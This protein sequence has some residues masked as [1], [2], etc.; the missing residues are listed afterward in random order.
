M[1]GCCNQHCKAMLLLFLAAAVGA[2]PMTKRAPRPV[3]GAFVVRLCE[4]HHRA[5]VTSRVVSRHA[6][7]EAPEF[8]ATIHAHLA[9]LP[10]L[11]LVVLRNASAA[12]IA[13]LEASHEVCGI[14]ASR[15]TKLHDEDAW[16]MDRL[17]Q[18]MLPLDGDGAWSGA[19][20]AG[21]HIFVLDTGL[22]ATHE[23]FADRDWNARDLNVASYIAGDE[24]AYNPDWGWDVGDDDRRRRRDRRRRLRPR[25]GRR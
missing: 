5:A 8:Q 3:P 22:D 4:E 25:R 24:W 11:P 6:A 7:P 20:G 23:E 17:N 12:A 9:R 21:V 14:E 16:H 13:E 1:V 2:L 19:T 15:K 10:S 18:E